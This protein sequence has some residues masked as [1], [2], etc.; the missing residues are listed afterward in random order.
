MKQKYIFPALRRI[1][2]WI[3]VSI[4]L[5]ALLVVGCTNQNIDQEFRITF[6]QLFSN[7]SQYN[8]KDISIEGFVFLGFEIMVISEELKYSGYAEG[9]LIPSGRMLWIEGGVPI[10]IYNELSIQNMMGPTERYSKVLVKGIFKY[11]DRYGHL[12][13]YEFQITPGEMQLLDWSPI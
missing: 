8:G 13:G 12:G 4:S 1:Q 5:T 9:H 10:E 3:I 7:P 2:Y 11:G 6:E